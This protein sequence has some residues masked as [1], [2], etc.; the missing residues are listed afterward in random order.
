MTCSSAT[1]RNAWC[2]SL[3]C[4]VP[5]SRRHFQDQHD[6]SEVFDLMIPPRPASDRGVTARPVSSRASRRAVW[7]GVSEASNLPPGNS[8]WLGKLVARRGQLDQQDVALGVADQAV[9]GDAKLRTAGRLASLQP[10]LP[11]ERSIHGH[12]R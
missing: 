8:H 11:A 9:T 7:P 4:T 12:R 6:H 5:L 1:H 3:S 10:L 2:S